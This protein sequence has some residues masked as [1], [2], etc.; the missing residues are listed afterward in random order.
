M[1]GQEAQGSTQAP[2]SAS[3]RNVLLPQPAGSRPERLCTMSQ[4]LRT[5][6]LICLALC[7]LMEE[8][9]G[10]P[11]SQTSGSSSSAA[12]RVRSKRCSCNNW[13]D[14]EC[15]YFCHLD[16][17]WV[18]TPSKI[19]PYGLGSPLSRRRRSAGRC[20]CANPNDATC[21]SFCHSS[22]M[23]PSLVVVVSPLEH[24]VDKA[25]KDLLTYFRQVAKANLIAAEHSA[26]PRK[27]PFQ[28]NKSRIS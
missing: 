19:T 20:Q 3:G 14:K 1:G 5:G 2:V 10:A 17:I 28:T 27:K 22:T 26:T 16:I 6:L 18:N 9:F 15:I 8:G 23:D 13:M 11:V 21:S 4:F 7:V 25:G 24:D 12:K